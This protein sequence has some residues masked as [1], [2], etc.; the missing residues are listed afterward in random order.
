MQVA[1]VPLGTDWIAQRAHP[2]REVVS[3]PLLQGRVAGL[4]CLWEEP[5]FADLSFTLLVHVSRKL[6][7]PYLLTVLAAAF[8]VVADP[9]DPRALRALEDAAL[10]APS[11]GVP[12]ALVAC[13]HVRLPR[14]ARTRGRRAP[15]RSPRGSW[16]GRPC[17]DALRG[18]SP[19]DT[20]P[21][22][23]RRL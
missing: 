7:R 23:T 13:A 22:V 15:L 5:P 16:P 9:P 1:A 6:L 4:L 18:R 12:S 17:L 2:A 14:T 3:D 19:R 20:A 8:I 11:S 10:P 21:F